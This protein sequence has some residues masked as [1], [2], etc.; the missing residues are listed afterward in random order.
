MRQ[1]LSV[2]VGLVA[3]F[4]AFSPLIFV[5]VLVAAAAGSFA[6]FGPLELVLAAA[7]AVPVGIWAGR[8]VSRSLRPA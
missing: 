8:A 6:G 1:V 3:W 5:I 4:A 2:V 7:F